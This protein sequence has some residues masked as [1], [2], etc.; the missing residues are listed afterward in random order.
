M[1]AFFF[2]YV[3]ACVFVTGYGIYG[4]CAW[5]IRKSER[6]QL[7]NYRAEVLL[8][9]ARRAAARMALMAGPETPVGIAH[10]NA[11]RFTR[12]V[13]VSAPVAVMLTSITC[14]THQPSIA[15]RLLLEAR[16]ANLRG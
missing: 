13:P 1:S 12:T 5:L 4:M 7:S 11:S 10:A 6:E 8:A 14:T 15:N 2:G 16:E 9:E 3:A